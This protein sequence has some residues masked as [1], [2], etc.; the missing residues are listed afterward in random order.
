MFDVDFS[1]LLVIFVVALVVLGPKRLPGLVSSIGRW[2]GKARSMARQFRE[3]LESE[4][5]LHDLDVT[6]PTPRQPPGGY[7]PPPPEFGGEPP[8]AAPLDPASAGQAPTDEAPADPG[9]TIPPD[10]PSHLDLSDTSDLPPGG[11]HERT[12]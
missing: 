2:V 9:S 8:T 11:N 6:R 1:E 7:P 10:H 5:Q 12:P 3:Q 4:V